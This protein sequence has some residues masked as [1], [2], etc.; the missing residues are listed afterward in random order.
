MIAAGL[1]PVL[2][3][4]L[5]SWLTPLSQVFTRRQQRCINLSA[6]LREER[7][8]QQPRAKRT[9]LVDSGSRSCRDNCL[10]TLQL[11]WQTC[12]WM[13]PWRIYQYGNYPECEINRQIAVASTRRERFRR[14]N[15]LRLCFRL[16]FSRHDFRK[17]C[18]WNLDWDCCYSTLEEAKEVEVL[19]ASEQDGLM[20]RAEV[21]FTCPIERSHLA[22]E[23]YVRKTLIVLK[24]LNVHMGYK[25][26]WCSGLGDKKKQKKTT[27]KS[28]KSHACLHGHANT[29]PHF[30]PLTVHS[31][32]PVSFPRLIMV[33]ELFNVKPH[34]E[35][36]F[37]LC[38]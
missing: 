1:S 5:S 30:F 12:L 26:V 16:S 17:V 37:S 31:A 14:F 8:I 38:S 21:L 15:S 9:A 36:F 29:S 7:S 13:Y 32:Q 23:H 20:G 18:G 6:C 25:T 4:L 11:C 2:E 27:T 10:Q 28:L 33:L 35:I 22:W 19:Q 3:M 24:N 34:V